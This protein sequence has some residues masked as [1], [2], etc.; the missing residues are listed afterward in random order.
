M[1][2]DFDKVIDRTGTGSEKWADWEGTDVLPLPVAD[3]DFLSPP[4]I[5][6]ALE[7]RVQ[8]GVFGYARPTASLI[9]SVVAMCESRYGWK[10]DPEWIVWL[11]GL[12][13]G[14]HVACRAVG[15][16]GDA[17]MTTTPAYP[18]FLSAPRRME[19]ALVSVSLVCEDGYWG[20]DWEAMEEAVT[21]E[22]RLFMFCH[23]H[24]PTGRVFRKDE[25]ERL[26]QFCLDRDIVICSDE[27]HCDLILDDL[28]H[29]SMAS[30]SDEVA[31]KTITLM[32]PSKTYNVAGLGC[33][34]AVIPDAK[35]RAAFERAKEGIVPMVTV[36]GYTACE[37]A[38]RYGEP[39]R[40]ELIEYLR[41]NRDRVLSFIEE[42][43]PEIKT[44]PVEA[45][46]LAWLDVRELQLADPIAFFKKA[47]V[48]LSDGRFFGGDGFV[49]LNFGCP[50]SIL[51]TALER[52]RRAV[53]E[54]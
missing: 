10:I 17:V 20:I 29:I 26:A 13:T 30:L 51:D 48:E 32:A 3:M 12:V 11:P 53:R 45:T 16:K 7:K 5:L 40:L 27:V 42:E 37:A 31:D 35:L 18:P 52:I 38:Y 28:P 54:R 44:T 50:R 43:I 1:E 24:N 4:A 34:F 47:G 2:F 49:R 46:Y 25:L 39:W 21:P 36:F 19:R 15:G 22:T 33:S 8:H 41:G 6:E 23:P 9:E 14:I